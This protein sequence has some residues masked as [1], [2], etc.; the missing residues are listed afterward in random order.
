MQRL[1][2]CRKNLY[3]TQYI[4]TIEHNTQEDEIY[5]KIYQAGE[6]KN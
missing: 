1:Q 5:L 4:H 3:R 6:K 2:L